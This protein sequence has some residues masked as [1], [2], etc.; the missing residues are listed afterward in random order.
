VNLA[1][2]APAALAALAALLVP[3][4]VHLQRRPEQRVVE[5]AAL[6]WLSE[7]VRPRQRLRLTEILLLL[8]RLLLVATLALWLAQPVW[9][10]YLPRAH[11]WELVVPGIDP[12]TLPA[13]T[14]AQVPERRWLA[15]GFPALDTPP[16]IAPTAVASLLRDLDTRL[17]PDVAVAVWVPRELAGLDAERIR[18]SRVVDW[19]VVDAAPE[20]TA[21]PAATAA[22]VVAIR[23]D[24]NDEPALRYLKAAVAAWNAGEPGRYRVQRAGADVAVPDEADW[25]VWI[26]AEP[27]AP[28]VDWVREGGHALVLPPSSQEA[29]P[30]APPVPTAALERRSIGRGQL[31]ASALPLRADSWPTLL[32]AE[33]PSIL[34]ELLQGEPAAPDRADA[35]AARPAADGARLPPPAYPVG[36]W[37]ALAIALLLLAERLLATRTAWRAPA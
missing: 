36:D 27:P 1:F 12:A 8:L 33:F 23:H 24:D 26:G 32:D 11:A 37:M 6:R 35:L 21:A 10:D 30:V 4:L 13:S 16:P 31:V 2:L 3:L 34:R 22:I 28:V 9:L 15:P 19:R 17:R 29:A 20:P 7:R 14:D 25:L 18:L 5:F